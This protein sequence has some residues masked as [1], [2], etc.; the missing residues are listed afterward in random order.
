MD[1]GLSLHPDTER[2]IRKIVSS[3]A[4]AELGA[5][6]RRRRP[7][8]S[9][10]LRNEGEP[11]EELFANLRDSTVFISADLPKIGP[12]YEIF[13]KAR[14]GFDREKSLSS[15]RVNT[16]QTIAIV[17]SNIDVLP[18]TENQKGMS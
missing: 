14:E 2:T 6:I 18:K 7:P 16:I 11:S 15:T 3:T 17:E 5:R 9:A 12:Y 8:S 13:Y 10:A 1:K 4:A